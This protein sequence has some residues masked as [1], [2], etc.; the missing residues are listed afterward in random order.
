MNLKEEANSSQS[1]LIKF[2]DHL[3]HIFI[4]INDK[5][6]TVTLDT[7]NNV[8]MFANPGQAPLKFDFALKQS[9]D[10]IRKDI[11]KIE[12]ISARPIGMFFN[13]LSNI[14]KVADDS[15]DTTEQADMQKGIED[16]YNQLKTVIN[17]KLKK[18]LDDA[19]TV[20]DTEVYLNMISIVSYLLSVLTRVYIC[21]SLSSQLSS[22]AGEHTSYVDKNSKLTTFLENTANLVLKLDTLPIDTSSP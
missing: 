17:D 12:I 6:T 5:M 8:L 11:A 13:P 18:D 22:I 3:F 4:S 2:Y 14:Y 16:L 21:I 9:V 20:I 15:I 19:N 1:M 10:D 7:V